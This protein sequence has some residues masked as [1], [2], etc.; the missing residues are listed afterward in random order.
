MNDQ[1]AV[2]RLKVLQQLNSL[3][4]ATTAIV[5]NHCQKEVLDTVGRE[6][7]RILNARACVIS[8]WDRVEN[9]LRTIS[10]S[11]PEAREFLIVERLSN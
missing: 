2:D 4:A 3:H 5:S 9:V 8:E 7:T 1:S 10:G 11:W 6:M